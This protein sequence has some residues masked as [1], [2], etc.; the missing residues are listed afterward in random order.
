MTF[1]TG[2]SGFNIKATFFHQN[3]MYSSPDLFNKRSAEYINIFV[4]V[5]TM[6]LQTWTILSIKAHF[7]K[8]KSNA[9]CCYNQFDKFSG[10]SYISSVIMP[11]FVKEHICKEKLFYYISRYFLFNFSKLLKIKF[12]KMLCERNGL[13]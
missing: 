12:L 2:N 13:Y 6:Q 9:C 4:E 8:V 11:I 1:L 3:F 10:H 7:R 5:F